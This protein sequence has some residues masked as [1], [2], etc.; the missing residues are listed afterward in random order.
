MQTV[1]LNDPGP[2]GFFSTI[3]FVTIAVVNRRKTIFLSKPSFGLDNED[4]FEV[5]DAN[6]CGPQPRDTEHE[7]GKISDVLE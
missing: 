2:R 4:I 3:Y 5:I 6:T 7:V 1:I